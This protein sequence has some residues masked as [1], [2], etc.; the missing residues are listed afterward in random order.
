M[1]KHLFSNYFNCLF[2]EMVKKVGK[3]LPRIVNGKA[4][5]DW[6]VIQVLLY[7]KTMR[8]GSELK[9]FLA[10]GICNNS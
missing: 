6:L 8:G 1:R 10:A 3:Y 7:D 9:V 4:F 5:L 2:A